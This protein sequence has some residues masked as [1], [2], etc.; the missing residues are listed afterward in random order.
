MLSFTK[1]EI[2]KVTKWQQFYIDTTLEALDQQF[3]NSM[4]ELEKIYE[5]YYQDR[6]KLVNELS[7][8]ILEFKVTGE[9]MELNAK[10]K[11]QIQNKLN[12]T[13]NG[14]IESEKNSDKAFIEETLNDA[15]K[16]TYGYKEYILGLG[17]DF[18]SLPLDEKEVEKIINNKVAGVNWSNRL[19]N[20]KGALENQLRKDIFDFCKGAISINKINKQIQD[21]FNADKNN[22]KRLVRTELCR[23]Q[24]EIL[25]KFDK[26]HG[27]EYQLFM[28]TLD[29][30]TSNICQE[31]DGKSFEINDINKPNPPV[32]T[33]PN[34]RSVLVGI[35]DSTYKP[36]TRRDNENKTIIAYKK[37]N[38]WNKGGN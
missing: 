19:W 21:R 30:K 23:S 32:G 15:I 27:A 10:E 5:K 36:P 13:V 38:E 3:N 20:N 25:N 24:Q 8:T 12:N 29:G 37:Y 35:P 2:M 9:Y 17:I 11:K 6:E 34:C 22:A 18:K 28:A 33:H 16:G 31:N 1:G 26:D 4:A 7:R 14:F